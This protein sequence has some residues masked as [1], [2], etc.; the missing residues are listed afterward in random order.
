M[1]LTTGPTFLYAERPN[2]LESI[3]QNIREEGHGEIAPGSAET[4]SQIPLSGLV[5]TYRSR[6]Y[7]SLEKNL[8]EISRLNDSQ[9]SGKTRTG[10][11]SHQPT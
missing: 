10:S 4:A 1:S 2:G 7:Q 9:K 3:G 11:C 8:P 5:C 6:S